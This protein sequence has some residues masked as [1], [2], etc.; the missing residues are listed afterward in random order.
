MQVLRHNAPYRLHLR[1]GVSYLNKSYAASSDIYANGFKVDA[2]I[3]TENYNE[4]LFYLAY[5]GGQVRDSDEKLGELKLGAGFNL[6]LPFHAFRPYLSTGLN[7]TF[8]SLEE[9]QLNSY[10]SEYEG[11]VGLGF[12]IGFGFNIHVGG[13]SLLFFEFGYDDSSV[14]ID[15]DE[16]S[17]GGGSFSVGFKF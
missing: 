15:G 12:Y 5:M 16:Y 8:L 2:G 9:G 7:L 10:N 6:V 13:G 17:T 4:A 14:T 11:G 1:M 3:I